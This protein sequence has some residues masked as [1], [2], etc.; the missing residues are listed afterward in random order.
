MIALTI[1]KPFDVSKEHQARAPLKLRTAV[2][3]DARSGT[4]T[5]DDKYLAK[6]SAPRA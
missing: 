2:S 4:R 3:L 5:M 1:V 6:G